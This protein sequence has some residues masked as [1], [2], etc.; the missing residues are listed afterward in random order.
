METARLFNFAMLMAV[1]AVQ[2]SCIKGAHPDMW[3]PQAVANSA[4]FIA[5]F[6]RLVESTKQGVNNPRGSRAY[7]STFGTPYKERFT[8]LFSAAAQTGLVE[9]YK[10]LLLGQNQNFKATIDLTP[11]FFKFLFA[12]ETLIEIAQMQNLY[13]Q[14]QPF[15]YTAQMFEG[16][17][18]PV[19]GSYISPNGTRTITAYGFLRGL[20]DAIDQTPKSTELMSL[21]KSFNSA[22]DQ[23]ISMQ[24]QSLMTLNFDDTIDKLREL[25]RQGKTQIAQDLANVLSKY[26]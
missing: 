8:Q 11:Q 10:Q 3:T 18:I 21:L 12:P 4:Y 14:G 22:L 16:K 25:F 2:A 17:Q 23:A 26:R 24:Q 13:G 6:N 19:I 15:A 9:Q 5:K 20:M 7:G 1:F